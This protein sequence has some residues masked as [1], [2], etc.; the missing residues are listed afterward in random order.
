M[1]KSKRARVVHESQVAKKSR[2]EQ[3]KAIFTNVQA[4]V[5]KYEHLF[6]FTLDNERNTYLKDIRAEFSDSR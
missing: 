6:I 1:A 5:D 2:K 3:T 4:A